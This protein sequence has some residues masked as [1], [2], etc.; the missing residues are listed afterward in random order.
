MAYI[1]EVEQPTKDKSKKNNKL[2]Y[3]ALVKANIAS[4]KDPSETAQDAPTPV[5]SLDQVKLIYLN[6]SY[7]A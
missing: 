5:Q 6:I 3:S 2:Y 4:I 1:D 7:Q